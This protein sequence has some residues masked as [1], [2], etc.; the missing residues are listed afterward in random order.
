MKA[1]DIQIDFIRLTVLELSTASRQAGA[2]L[3]SLRGEEMEEGLGLN[4][5]SLSSQ[6]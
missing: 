4:Q 5:N 6:L 2:N 1:T 3:E